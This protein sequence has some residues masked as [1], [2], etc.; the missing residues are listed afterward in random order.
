M[1]YYSTMV[2]HIKHLKAVLEVLR[3]NQLF[4]K[5]SKCTFAQQNI[6]Y[7]GHIISS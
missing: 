2:D 6:E 3:Q 1:T 5:K 4:A 7:L